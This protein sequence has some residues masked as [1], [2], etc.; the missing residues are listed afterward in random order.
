MRTSDHQT[1]ASNV[2]VL[3]NSPHWTDNIRFESRLRAG[4]LVHERTEHKRMTELYGALL[5]CITVVQQSLHNTFAA[6]HIVADK[7]R[8]MSRR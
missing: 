7:L 5:V 3:E 8:G 1:L 4:I 2:L 6:Y